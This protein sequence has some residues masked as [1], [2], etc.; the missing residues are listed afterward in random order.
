MPCTAADVAAHVARELSAIADAD[1]REALRSRT[2]PPEEHVR[3]WEWGAPGEAYPCWTVVAD[4]QTDTAIVYSEHGFGPSDPWGL[5]F[6]SRP[7]YGMD[8]AW[9]MRLEDAFVESFMGAGLAIWDVVVEDEPGTFRRL[10]ASLTMDEA[11]AMRDDLAARDPGV[12]YHV[13][14]RSLPEA[15]VP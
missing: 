6:I 9:F 2:G 15:G 5:V 8:S 4:P 3:G 14:Y 12:R 10:A 13:V 7:W 11:F 1:V